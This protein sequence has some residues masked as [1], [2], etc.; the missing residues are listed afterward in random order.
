MWK[1]QIYSET[2]WKGNF[3]TIHF[4]INLPLCRK[5]QF[6]HAK[7]KKCVGYNILS[8]VQPI[9]FLNQDYYLSLLISTHHGGDF[10]NIYHDNTFQTMISTNRITELII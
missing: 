7:Q 10:H 3:S 9:F 5:I 8:R 2:R 4:K 1:S 6:K